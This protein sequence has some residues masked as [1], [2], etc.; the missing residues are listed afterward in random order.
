MCGRCAELLR[1]IDVQRTRVEHWLAVRLFPFCGGPLALFPRVL[2][3][4]TLVGAPCM[5]IDMHLSS[6]LAVFEGSPVK[7]VVKA[8]LY[9]CRL[10]VIASR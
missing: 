9:R 8:A 10:H 4:A 6:M 5:G 7:L 2:F 3:G 1:A